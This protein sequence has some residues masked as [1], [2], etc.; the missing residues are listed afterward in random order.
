VSRENSEATGT[1]IERVKL[2]PTNQID[3]EC[4]KV[5]DE[6]KVTVWIGVFR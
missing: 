6:P 5:I 1:G 2:Y 4:G 3:D